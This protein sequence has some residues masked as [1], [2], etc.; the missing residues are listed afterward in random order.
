MNTSPN[1]DTSTDRE[2]NS[3][4][5][6][7]EKDLGSNKRYI[8]HYTEE[9][10]FKLSDKVKMALFH[11]FLMDLRES[12]RGAARLAKLINKSPSLVKNWCAYTPRSK[13]SNTDLKSLVGIYNNVNKP[14]LLLSLEKLF[15]IFNQDP[16]VAT[17][18][19]NNSLGTSDT[20]DTTVLQLMEDVQK[21]IPYLEIL[22]MNPESAKMARVTKNFLGQELSFFRVHEVLLFIKPDMYNSLG[23]DYDLGFIR[24]IGNLLS[25]VLSNIQNTITINIFNPYDTTDL[26]LLSTFLV[27]YKDKYKMCFYTSSKQD[28]SLPYSIGQGT[29]EAAIVFQDTNDIDPLVFIKRCFLGARA[30]HQMA[31]TRGDIAD[32]SSCDEILSYYTQESSVGL[33]DTFTKYPGTGIFVPNNTYW[34]KIQ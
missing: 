30:K 9:E 21:A 1:T 13:P 26:E 14:V 19:I 8:V 32:K 25:E 11:V 22:G 16:A 17:S 7:Y 29:A 28:H 4:V 18:I 34:T 33:K 2:G 27:Q 24:E 15:I 20:P 10:L 31:V 23:E 12:V 3:D 5:Q 6:K